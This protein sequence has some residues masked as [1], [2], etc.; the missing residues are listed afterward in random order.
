MHR[1]QYDIVYHI[2]EKSVNVVSF[3]IH[4]NFRDADTNYLK[5]IED[6]RTAKQEEE[7]QMDSKMIQDIE[8]PEEKREST[9]GDSSDKSRMN[10]TIGSPEEIRES[11]EGDSSKIRNMNHNIAIPEEINESVEVDLSEIT[12][13]NHNIEI[14]EE[15]KDKNPVAASE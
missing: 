11:T 6:M 12:N 10:Q 9:A 8:I 2:G 15:I 14:Q 7:I 4:F 1:R 3:S 5:Q 13:M